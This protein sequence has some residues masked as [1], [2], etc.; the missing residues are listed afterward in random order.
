M[1]HH[2]LFTS[3]IIKNIFLPLNLFINC[4]NNSSTRFSFFLFSLNCQIEYYFCDLF[5]FPRV[6]KN[7]SLYRSK[8]VFRV[9][10]IQS[11]WFFL[12]CLFVNAVFLWLNQFY[13]KTDYNFFFQNQKHY[14]HFFFFTI[15]NEKHQLLTNFHFFENFIV[16][17]AIFFLSRHN[18]R[19]QSFH[20]KLR[21]NDN[22]FIF[23]ITQSRLRH[24]LLR[25]FWQ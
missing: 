12:V 10:F 14:K 1:W 8:F 22:Y 19:M 23:S 3:N 9:L 11:V 2:W 5:F 6:L 17:N 18:F 21:Q 7:I 20:D 24:V 13:D 4:K 16:K 25:H 15:C